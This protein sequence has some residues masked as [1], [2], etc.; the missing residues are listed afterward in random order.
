MKRFHITTFTAIVVLLCHCSL[1]PLLAR[2]L[3]VGSGKS[4][5]R[6][7]SAC[8]VATAGDTIAISAGV[9]SGGDVAQN[10]K[11]TA[12]NWIVIRGVGEVIFRGSAQAF[13]ISDAEY[14]RIEHLIF[15]QQTSN[16]VNLDDAGSFDTP[17]HHIVIEDCEWRGMAATGNNDELK[18]SGIDDFVVRR[19]R[20]LHGAAGG[21]MVDMVGCHRGVFEDNLFQD[22]G[23]NCLQAKGASQH[24]LV[25]RCSFIEG[26]DRAIN[27]G[28]STG[29]AFFRPLGATFE[30]ADMTV[31]SCLFSGSQAPIAFVGAV[32]CSTYHCTIIAPERWAVRILQEN[33]SAGM[34]A[35]ANNVFVNNIVEF[36]SAQPAFNI[37]PNT[38]AGSFVVGHNLWY[39][40][41]NAQWTGPNSPSPEQGSVL[42]QSPRFAD[43]L[44]HL[45]DES[46]ALHKGT[47]VDSTLVDLYGNHF[48]LPPS[49]GAVER[50]ET[51][52]PYCD[53]IIIDSIA[54][55]HEFK[56]F[57][58]RAHNISLKTWAYPQMRMTWDDT[59]T[60]AS[61][62]EVSVASLLDSKTGALKGQQEF[63]IR[64]RKAPSTLTGATFNFSISMMFTDD[65][66]HFDTCRYK[67]FFKMTASSVPDGYDAESVTRSVRY[68]N[69]G[70]TP[71]LR[72]PLDADADGNVTIRD[73]CGRICLSRER[74]QSVDCSALNAGLYHLSVESQG[75]EQRILLLLSR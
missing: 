57:A 52:F 66:V 33:T 25:Q 71:V 47:I 17:A 20:F 21:S 10:L 18:L 24:I 13:Q 26:G 9:Y 27:I 73:L 67:T 59:T 3:E 29:A 64:C 56:H 49:M 16:G 5:A 23:S 12:S 35:C 60:Y 11:G 28:G 50:A 8:A 41:T 58:V 14:L 32:R 40:R 54:Y 34:L 42:R 68:L 65:G 51:S 70:L 55:V 63:I 38:D 15:E 36:I 2:V 45:S 37:G 39:H 46:P 7:Q 74:C 48:A 1:Q 31:R 4:Y 53:S 62:E 75:Q 43:T 22:G 19:C 6:L 69:L 44:F 72:L 30:V 61:A